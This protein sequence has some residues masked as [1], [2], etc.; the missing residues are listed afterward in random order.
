MTYLRMHR[1]PA[2]GTWAVRGLLGR[3]A[4]IPFLTTLLVIVVVVYCVRLLLPLLGLPE[5]INTVVMVIVGLIALLMLLNSI[6]IVGTGPI[7]RIGQR[8]AAIATHLAENAPD[9]KETPDVDDE[10][11]A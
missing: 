10:G 11:R 4:L 7:L 1:A 8:H 6:G 9:P 2:H 5:P 3:M